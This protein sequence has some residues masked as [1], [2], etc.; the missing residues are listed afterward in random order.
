MSSPVRD[1]IAAELALLEREVDTPVAPFGYGTDVSC[2]TDLDP[3]LASVDQNSTQGIAEA[4]VRRLDCP[5]GALPDDDD[6]GFDVASLLNTGLTTTQINALAG[7]VRAEITKDDRV[8]SATV[9]LTPSADGTE[10]E[11]DINVVPADPNTSQFSMVLAVSDGGVLL[12]E[13]SQ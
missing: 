10:L 11:L 12:E 8:A 1:A 9:R 4:I 5:R 2:T 7:Q 6:Y 13:I 3:R